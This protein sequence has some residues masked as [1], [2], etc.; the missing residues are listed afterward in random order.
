MTVS[1]VS[2]VPSDAVFFSKG[3]FPSASFSGNGFQ[4]FSNVFIVLNHFQ[5]FKTVFN[6][7]ASVLLFTHA[8]RFSVSRMQDFYLYLTIIGW[9][10]GRFVAVISKTIKDSVLGLNC[11]HVLPLWSG[12]VWT[13][14]YGE[15]LTIVKFKFLICITV[16]KNNHACRRQM[17]LSKHLDKSLLT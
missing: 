11:L 13:D 1:H 10:F 16:N 17:Y 12:N 2:I 3:L 8:E 4:P 9:F 14:W 6:R 15:Q 7:L 5:L